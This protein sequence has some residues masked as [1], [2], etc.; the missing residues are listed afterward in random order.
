M[1]STPIFD[2]LL[3]EQDPETCRVI[4]DAFDIE[5]DPTLN[6]VTA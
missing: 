1:T 5:L 4:V 6:E 2:Q 3:T